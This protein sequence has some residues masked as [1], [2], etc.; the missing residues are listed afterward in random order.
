LLPSLPLDRRKYGFSQGEEEHF[1]GRPLT[2]EDAIMMQEL[3]WAEQA[4]EDYI[5]KKATMHIRSSVQAA[6]V[7]TE[8][9]KQESMKVVSAFNDF[10]L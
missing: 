10:L 3:E 9:W 6:H 1:L 4:M 2:F 7:H 8:E 5:R